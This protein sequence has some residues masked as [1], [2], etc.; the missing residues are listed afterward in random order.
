MAKRSK[1][2]KGYSAPQDDEE[3]ARLEREADA[4]ADAPVLEQASEPPADVLPLQGA[5]YEDAPT[6]DDPSELAAIAEVEEEVKLP[7]SVV[8]P[9]FKEKYLEAAKRNGISGKAAKRSNWD[10]LAQQIA[11]ACLNE[12]HSIRISDFVALLEAN[13][14]D[15]SR[16]TNRNKGWE[17]R[18]RMTGRVA[19]QKVVANAGALKLADGSEVAAPEEWAAKYRDKTKA[20]A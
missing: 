18:F 3:I 6:E 15:H 12:K 9:K 7:N 19:L 16:W 5:Q 8:A 10:W 1:K 13:G 2:S 11:A 14:V 20:E 4:K 17:G